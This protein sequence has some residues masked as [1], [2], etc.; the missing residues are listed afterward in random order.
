[1]ERVIAPL[2]Y[3]PNL[4]LSIKQRDSASVPTVECI[5]ESQVGSEE[6]QQSP[7]S[8]DQP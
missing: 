8:D 6:S 3:P 5:G 2:S 7:L 1:M 4:G